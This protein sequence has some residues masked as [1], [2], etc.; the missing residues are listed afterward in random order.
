L[1]GNFR[2]SAVSPIGIGGCRS[3]SSNIKSISTLMEEADT[4]D[5]QK[6]LMDMLKKVSLPLQDTMSNLN[7]VIN[8]Q[9]NLGLHKIFKY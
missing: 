1:D 6:E 4:P 2:S 8:V 5:E 7:E 3:H 9:S